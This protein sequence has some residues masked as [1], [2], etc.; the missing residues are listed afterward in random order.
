MMR[1]GTRRTTVNQSDELRVDA[2]SLGAS[3]FGVADLTP[4][5]AEIHQ[6][7]GGTV[8]EFATAISIGVA[9]PMA[10][11]DRIGN[12]EDRVAL[13]SYR[14]HGYDVINPRLDAI[15]SRLASQLQDRGFRAFPV[16]ASQTVDTTNHLG[17]F[18]HKLAAHLSGLGWIGKSCLL[19]T[20]ESGPRVRWASVLTDA[21]LQPT[22]SPVDERCGSCTECVDICPAAAF[23]GVAFREE[24]PRS[25]RFDVWKC[26]EHQV[27][28]AENTG[29][30]LCGLCLY[31]CPHGRTTSR[32]STQA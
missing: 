16:A 29:N 32:T 3:F 7:G 12:Q 8:S 23:T 25:V 2:I 26:R 27:H 24:D 22:G 28:L 9:L 30:D 20:P 11:V 6:Q 18:S 10:I 15:A 21:P 19:V 14:H 1:H 17:A 5:F 4:A 13:M 31:V